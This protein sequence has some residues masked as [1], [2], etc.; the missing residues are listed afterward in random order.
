MQLA[1]A[2]VLLSLVHRDRA[3]KKK[4]PHLS[5]L[6]FDQLLIWLY[7]AA[8]HCIDLVED[9]VMSFNLMSHD[10]GTGLT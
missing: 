8:Q 7:T 1:L 4:T 2:R 3:G 5:P 9:K 6:P 10:V